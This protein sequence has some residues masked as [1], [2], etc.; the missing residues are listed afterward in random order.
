MNHATDVNTF[1]DS[2]VSAFCKYMGVSSELKNVEVKEKT[3][4]EKYRQI[5]IY[6]LPFKSLVV[7]APSFFSQ[8]ETELE[9]NK[10]TTATEIKRILKLHDSE[11]QDTY[12]FFYLNPDYFI[13]SPLPEFCS[14]RELNSENRY[15]F[16]EFL[17]VCSDSDKQ[18]GAVSPD[19]PV[20]FV[21]FYKGKTGAVATYSF[22]GELLADIAVLTHPAYRKR[23]LGK[24]VLSALCRWGL[25]NNRISQYCCSKS[26]FASINLATSLK[27]EKLIKLERLILKHPNN[28][29]NCPSG[30]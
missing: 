16:K 25:Q 6:E 7:T 10:T 27:F 21:C 9:N 14:I 11:I 19:D 12:Y 3:D 29:V 24:A 15:V 22:W 28:S 4:F 17:E 20:C 18:T 5:F 1:S 23:G 26:N 2:V 8:L 30:L 13:P